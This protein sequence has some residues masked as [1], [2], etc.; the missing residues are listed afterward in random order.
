MFA[1]LKTIVELL[2]S[3]IKSFSGFKNAKQRETNVLELLGIYFLV[4]DCVDDGEKLILE[5]GPDPVAAITA[6]SPQN[7]ETTLHR[8]NA[9]LARQ[10]LR[11]RVLEGHILGQDQLTVINPGLQSRISKAIGY[12]MDSAVTLHGIGAALVF[13]RLV[14]TNEEA[15]SYVSVMSGSEDEHIDISRVQSDI[16]GLRAALDEYRVVVERFVSNDELLKLSKKARENT[17]LEQKDT[18]ETA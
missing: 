9:V 17:L 1:Q 4:K 5:S 10:I 18:S 6:M 14:T 3:G 2:S 16:S 13:R 15:A 8:W 11:L 12:K 7:A